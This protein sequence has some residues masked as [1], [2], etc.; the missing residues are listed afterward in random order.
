MKQIATL[1]HVGT[2]PTI[3]IVGRPNVGKSTLFNRLL[4][5]ERAITHDRAG[6][7]RD[8][9]YAEATL[10]GR[11]IALIDTGG[12]EVLSLGNEEPALEEQIAQQAKEAISEAHAIAF[13]VDGREGPTALDE[14]I[15]GMLRSAGK[16]VM[17]I[18]NKVDGA[19]HDAV[20]TAP[21]HTFG[22]ELHAVSAAHGY[23]MN[24]LVEVLAGMVK[25]IPDPELQ[26]DEETG[27]RL[28]F[29]GRPNAGKSS[30]TNAILGED[31]QIVSDIAGT[32][33]DSV[34]MRFEKK[35]KTYT[36]VDTAGVRRRTKVTDSLERFSVVRAITAAKRA[37]VAVLTIDATE[38]VTTQDKKLL[39]LMER[40]KVGFI[41][42]VNKLDLVERD[43]LREF[44]KDMEFALR[45]CPYAPVLYTSAVK[46]EGV[47]KILS[48]AETILAESK[49]RVGTGE[50]NRVL[51]EVLTRHQPPLVKRKRAK[52]YYMTQTGTE[53]LEFV[54]F[55]SNPK[56]I[57]S[58]YIK[59]MENQM[60]KLFRVKL[61]PIRMIFRASRD[62][63]QKWK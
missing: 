17:L 42:V 43:E 19:E 49:K 57:K 4:R 1:H 54:F 30:L 34:D 41:V 35:G 28:A 40:E 39:A 15:I 5:V 23:G 50:L 51:R 47:A 20:L 44:K 36:I 24:T 21:F 38:G 13:V 45:I 6:V 48:N 52:F 18:V 9:V 2:L 56:Y 14:E 26:D 62:D 32:T 3:A 27:L 12:I 8:R 61:A 22:L 33:R 31:R 10:E 37:N 11:T 46:R 55:V 60:R 63:R 53:P 25:D 59:Y 16:P 58:S 29:I 7:T